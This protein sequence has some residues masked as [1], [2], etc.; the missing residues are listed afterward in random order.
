VKLFASLL[1]YPLTWF[2][3]ATGAYFGWVH[4]E[5][6]FLSM[7]DSA[8]WAFIFVFCLGILGAILMFTYVRA[9]QRTLRALRIYWK[10]SQ[11]YDVWIHLREERA[12][13]CDELLKLAEDL[14]LPGTVNEEGRLIK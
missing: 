5:T 6:I 8:L 2:V 13:L 11:R 7:P 9:S 4:S 10:K 1:F 14:Q 12:R 3:W